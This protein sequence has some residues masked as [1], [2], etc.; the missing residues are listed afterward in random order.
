M[1]KKQSDYVWVIAYIK[2]DFIDRVEQDLLE[3]GYGAVKVYIPTVRVLKKQFKNRNIYE[4]VPLL[5][6]YGF[7]QLPFEKACDAEFLRQLRINIPAI[8]SWVSDPIR[9]LKDNPKLR[10]DNLS[11]HTKVALATEDEIATL[12]K[13]SE[14]MSV[15]SDGLID[16]LHIGQTI[17]L[18]GYPYD[19]MVA[20]IVKINKKTKKVKVKL[21][22]ETYITQAVVSFENIFYTVYSNYDDSCREESLDEIDFRGKRNLDKIYANIYY[23]NEDQ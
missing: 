14:N 2:R 12:L 10:Y 7:F 3:Y 18:R 19:N 21:L 1:V 8:H 15:F 22:L 6:N 4:Y 17:T 11:G 9:A 20:E 23:G 13:A 5:F 16:Q